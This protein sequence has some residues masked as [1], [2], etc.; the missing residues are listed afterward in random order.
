MAG[1]RVKPGWWTIGGLAAAAAIWYGTPRLLRHI[2][3]FDVRRIEIVGA[4]QLPAGVVLEALALPRDAN[5][6]D[7][8]GEA[9]Q[10]LRQVPGVSSAR[11][12]RRIPGTL[13]IVVDEAESV[14]LVPQEGGLAL[15]DATGLALPFDPARSAP[16]L[17][18][19][20]M[21]DS[22]LTSLLARVRRTD[23]DLFD[24]V[25][26][27]SRRDGDVVLDLGEWR[28]RLRDD[29]EPAVMLAVMEVAR[30]LD[31]RGWK[32]TELDARFDGQVIVRGRAA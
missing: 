8:F 2:G 18:V 25:S 26:A 31:R 13:R 14:A 23:P 17:P 9:E 4:R 27:A 12:T 21:A 16:D 5:V 15:L 11:I 20:M 29:A 10:R 7:R 6:F 30:D 24:Q 19:V 3:F 28:L 1:R 22:V 32:F